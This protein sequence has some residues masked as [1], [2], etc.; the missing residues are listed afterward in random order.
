MRQ[1]LT[2]SLL[3][4]SSSV[5]WAA[6]LA[7]EHPK[8][9]MMVVSKKLPG[10]AIYN[11]DTQQLVCRAKVGVLSPHEG[12]LSPDGRYAYV[13]VYG[14][15]GVGQPGTDEHKLHIFRTSDCKEVGVLD[16]GDNK[17]PHSIEVGK[18]GTIYLTTEISKSIVLIDPKQRRIV[19][20]IP[21]DS[22]TTHMLAVTPDEKTVYTANVQS[23]TVS[24]LDV[25][26]RKLAKVIQTEAEPQ[27]MALSPNQRW[28][29]TN[30]GPVHKIAFYR[31][32]DNQIDF[33]IPID[34]IPFVSKF[35]S[36]GKYLYNAGMEQGKIRVWKV[37]VAQ[38]KV[39]ATTSEELGKAIGS[40]EVNPF[41]GNVFL[42]SSDLNKI[43]EIDSTTWKVAKQLSTD[44]T[45]DCMVFATV[46]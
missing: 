13:P 26:G 16:T 40:L 19:A 18:S 27:R 34:G 3:A 39:L 17:R 7:A 32:S 5:L 15:S 12:A 8:R 38:R 23:K 29:V 24:V 22:P 11:A 1:F 25:P 46:K 37:D 4:V 21:T 6:S 44:Q 35:S 36:D 30:L 2:L 45:P 33:T 20:K 42:S 41:T 10:M 31:Q 28:F 9:L 14:S 43:S